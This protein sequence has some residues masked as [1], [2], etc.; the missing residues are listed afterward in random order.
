VK[1][2]L[3]TGASSGIGAAVAERFAA[4]GASL[5]LLGRDSRKLR[6]V[7]DAMAGCASVQT[8]AVDFSRRRV[9]A[10]EVERI[11]AR[12]P[13]LDALVHAAGVFVGG[14]VL[15]GDERSLDAM[16]EVNV[17][18][19]LSITRILLPLL[20]RSLGTVVFINSSG[21]LQPQR[22]TS[23]YMAGKHALK[24]LTDALRE[25]VSPRGVRVTSIYPGR[26]ATPMQRHLH[27]LEK[28]QYRP[29]A[30]LQPAD[31]AELVACAVN[32]PKSAE[33]VDAIVRPRSVGGV[34][35]RAPRKRRARR[36]A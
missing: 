21:V 1:S 12:L 3:V 19:A 32:L 35:Y 5:T 4:Q 17:H 27:D 6:A 13:S 7:A 15:S 33:L 26:T 14:S 24:G 31:V 10:R 9:V 20:E 16:L 36:A 2:V 11:A 29:E 8:C 34:R 23:L 28:R 30:L 25:E 18:A 22:I